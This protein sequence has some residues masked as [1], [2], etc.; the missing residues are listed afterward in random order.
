MA[1][2]GTKSFLSTYW[3]RVPSDPRQSKNVASSDCVSLS[4][5]WE[6]GIT[7]EF[8]IT[9][10]LASMHSVKWMTVSDL[11][12]FVT[13]RAH[14][15]HWWTFNLF[16]KL[17]RCWEDVPWSYLHVCIS[18]TVTRGKNCRWSNSTTSKTAAAL[19]IK[20]NFFCKNMYF[21]LWEC[22]LNSDNILTCL[23]YLSI[24]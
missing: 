14:Q 2:P 16:W 17:K 19:C 15:Y 22:W 10:E 11:F 4:E 5:R 9:E 21:L 6:R 20:L 7:K 3:A 13:V 23:F 8:E 12:T 24:A 18:V 1:A